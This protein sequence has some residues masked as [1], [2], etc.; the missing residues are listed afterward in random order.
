MTD[1]KM[2]ALCENQENVPK[3]EIQMFVGFADKK[4]IKD[5][6]FDPKVKVKESIEGLERE[7]TFLHLI[8]GTTAIMLM[9]FSCSRIVDKINKAATKLKTDRSEATAKVFRDVLWKYYEYVVFRCDEKNIDQK[10]E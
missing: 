3:H 2:L 7:L 10:Y 4:L 8:Q 5:S 9:M 1:L 6:S